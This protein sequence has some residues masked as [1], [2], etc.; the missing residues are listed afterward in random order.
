LNTIAQNYPAIPTLAVDGVY[1]PRTSEAVR[2]FQQIFDL[3]ATGVVD[4]P[5]WYKISFVYTAVARLAE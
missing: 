4:F 3:P 1:G 5:T 2:I